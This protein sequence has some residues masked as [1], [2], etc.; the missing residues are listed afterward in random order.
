MIGSLRQKIELLT[1]IRTPD[2][3]G[4]AI[5][6]WVTDAVHWASV[7]RLTSTRDFVGDRSNRLKRLAATIRHDD[8]ITLG[9]RIRFENEDYEVVSIESG[10]DRGR[11]LVLI[12][13]EAVGS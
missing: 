3:G 4:G 11:R 13:E 8:S 2:N 12:C 6:A 9:Q 5:I 10:D 7:E 1:S